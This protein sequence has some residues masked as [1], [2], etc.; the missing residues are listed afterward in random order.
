MKKAARVWELLGCPEKVAFESL[1]VEHG[2][3]PA[4][5][6]LALGWF[7]RWL[8]GAPDSDTNAGPAV[9]IEDY[10]TISCYP[11]ADSS[12]VLTLPELFVKKREEVMPKNP[13]PRMEQVREL[14]GTPSV[15]ELDMEPIQ[16][17]GTGRRFHRHQLPLSHRRRDHHPIHHLLA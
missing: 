16:T 9:L 5:R 1:P 11:S 8:K 6:S 14:F 7:N 12:Q 15:K 13:E 17:A 2:Y 3:P 10:A 4:A